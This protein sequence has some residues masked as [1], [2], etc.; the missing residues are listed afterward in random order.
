MQSPPYAVVNL[1]I[2]QT[3]NDKK[4]YKLKNLVNAVLR[5]VSDDIEEY[6]DDQFDNVRTNPQMD[7]R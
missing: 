1:A 5:R 2:I 6:N 7:V 4:S 3:K